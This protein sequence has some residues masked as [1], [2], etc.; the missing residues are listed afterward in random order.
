MRY[1]IRIFD[2]GGQEM[3]E[4]RTGIEAKDY[5]EADEIAMAYEDDC[6][7]QDSRVDWYEVDL[8]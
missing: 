8:G 7:D 4:L 2:E 3:L 6:S 1:L 5:K